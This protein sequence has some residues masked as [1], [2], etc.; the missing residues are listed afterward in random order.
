MASWRVEKMHQHCKGCSECAAAAIEWANK[1][2]A[3]RATSTD[4]T[5]DM[6]ALHSATVVLKSS[7]GGLAQP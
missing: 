4:H 5:A 7:E 1:T 2:D 3:D 6:V